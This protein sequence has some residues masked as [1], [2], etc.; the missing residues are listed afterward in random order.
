[1]SSLLSCLLALPTLPSCFLIACVSSS[2]A[3]F[4]PV[5]PSICGHVSVL[6]V[7]MSLFFLLAVRLGSVMSLCMSVCWLVCLSGCLPTVSLFV[8]RSLSSPISFSASVCLAVCLS[9]SICVSICLLFSLYVCLDSLPPS[10]SVC[11]SVCSS[12]GLVF[13]ASVRFLSFRPRLLSKLAA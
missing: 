12:L 10:L 11:P 4:V 6:S 3:V 13:L 8:C 1:M 5:C 7:C 2:K 9:V